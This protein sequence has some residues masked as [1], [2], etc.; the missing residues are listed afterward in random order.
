MTV[1]HNLPPSSY[2]AGETAGQGF[3]PNATDMP[4]Y[5]LVP[6]DP[7]LGVE[8]A[9]ERRLLNTT[10]ERAP[11][12]APSGI[13]AGEVLISPQHEA[14]HNK[15]IADLAADMGIPEEQAIQGLTP[16]EA[17]LL[18]ARL[19]VAVEA[20]EADGIDPPA[21]RRQTELPGPGAEGAPEASLTAVELAVG[22]GLVSSERAPVESLADASRSVRVEDRVE[23]PT[24]KPA[25]RRWT[26]LDEASER[27]ADSEPGD[28]TTEVIPQPLA[29]EQVGA[30]IGPGDP[31]HNEEARIEF[32]A[33][34]EKDA[35]E[36]IEGL[37]KLESFFVQGIE[38]D[39]QLVDRVDDLA[40][41]LAKGGYGIKTA[42]EIDPR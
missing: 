1:A 39:Q 5:E 22:S 35:A 26:G 13:E 10:A 11:D 6:G 34:A 32:E 37:K 12:R 18:G 42:Q 30:E 23:V 21:Q 38:Q 31:Q 3:A 41:S 27:N 4:G 2:L 19:E 25:R 9:A 29:E 20:L 16:G 24:S 14:A 15:L 36:L 7:L 33:Q 40:P 8:I 17:Q 28:T